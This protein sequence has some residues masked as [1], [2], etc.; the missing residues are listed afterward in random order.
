MLLA[1]MALLLAA[2]GLVPADSSL[3]ASGVCSNVSGHVVTVVEGGDTPDPRCITM[4]GSQALRIV[5][6]DS[7]T[8]H[9]RWRPFGVTTIP[10][11]HGHTFPGR[12]RTYLAPGA[13]TI[14][15]RELPYGAG[16]VCYKC[17]ADTAPTSAG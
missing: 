16:E 10:V 1:G 17:H 12:I 9:V 13:H 7:K 11:G 8:I 3:P 2:Q 15:I 4:R 5:N 6:H 14:H